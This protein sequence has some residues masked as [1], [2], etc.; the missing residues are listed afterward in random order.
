M[1]FVA[2]IQPLAAPEPL[3]LSVNTRVELLNRAPFAGRS[4]YTQNSLAVTMLLSKSAVACP[5]VLDWRSLCPRYMMPLPTS[6]TELVIVSSKM[7][8]LGF[9]LK[10]SSL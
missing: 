1:S 4:M 6:R 3:L 8:S 2:S 10:L 5:A 7:G 9:F